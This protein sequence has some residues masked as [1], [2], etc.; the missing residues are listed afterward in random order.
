MK[1]LADA[2]VNS[3]VEI[4][5]R[6]SLDLLPTPSKSHYIFNLRD[7]SK[8]I[9]GVLQADPSVIVDR[10]PMFRWAA[11]SSA[12]WEGDRTVI[13][14]NKWRYQKAHTHKCKTF[15]RPYINHFHFSTAI[16][17]FA[18]LVIEV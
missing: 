12:Y 5:I 10:E 13:V 3:A 4:Y 9:N 2:I 8:C 18:M 14:E 7:L 11:P 1:S 16:I 17:L 15:I 6:I